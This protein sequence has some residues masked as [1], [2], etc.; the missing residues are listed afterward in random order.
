MSKEVNQI[1]KAL[2]D[3][4]RLEIVCFLAKKGCASCKDISEKFPRLTQPTMSH[5]FKV[6]IEVGI[7]SLEK[8]G[9]E[10]KYSLKIKNLE[11]VGIDVKKLK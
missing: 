11:S 4:T 7:L 2:G 5:H 3:E 9:T 10:N 1:F 8:N 6:L